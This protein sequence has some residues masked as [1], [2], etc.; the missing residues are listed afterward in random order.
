LV[1]SK[2]AILK[3]KRYKVITDF[4]FDNFSAVTIVFFLLGSVISYWRSRRDGKD[5]GLD[6]LITKALNYTLFPTAFALLICAFYKSNIG[7]LAELPLGL[8]IAAVTL[9]YVAFKGIK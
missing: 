2:E 6:S 7:K 4:F 8:C 3:K 1:P 9:L 5:D